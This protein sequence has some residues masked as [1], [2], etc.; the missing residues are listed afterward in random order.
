MPPLPKTCPKTVSASPK[1]GSLSAERAFAKKFSGAGEHTAAA[2]AFGRGHTDRPPFR[3]G[4]GG[5]RPRRQRVGGGVHDALPAGASARILPS[6]RDSSTGLV[7]KSSQPAASAFSLS[8]DI[9][10]AVR[11]MTG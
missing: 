9:A 4:S 7:S 6:S 2:L 10:F 11:A 3:R 1:G 5:L 8:P